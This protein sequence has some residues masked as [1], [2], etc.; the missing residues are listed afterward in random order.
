MLK[1]VI[2]RGVSKRNNFDALS[3]YILGGWRSQLG[4]L[5]R[6]LI[7]DGELSEAILEGSDDFRRSVLH[8]LQ[9]WT[10]AEL[11]REEP[12]P[13]L[14]HSRDFFDKVWPRQL[15]VRTPNVS[16]AIKDI[17][18]RDTRLME[19]YFE[20]AY[21][22]LSPLEGHVHLYFREDEKNYSK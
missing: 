5:T 17:L 21:P 13:F 14:E 3:G 15:R 8:Y 7:T 11:N 20:D 6:P 4:N 9:D 19:A 10:L 18:I 2:K 12:S 1:R 22:Y 16:K